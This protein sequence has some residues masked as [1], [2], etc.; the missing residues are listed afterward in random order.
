MK[1]TL[2]FTLFSIFIR[3]NAHTQQ[4]LHHE[5]FNYNA[6]I[7]SVFL[8]P[9]TNTTEPSRLLA[10]PIIQLNGNIPLVL[11]FD[12]L[13]A[14]YEQYHVKIIH[15]NYDWAP[16]VLSEIE[17]LAEYNDAIINNYAVSQGTK[18]SYY[19]YAFEVPP[20]KLSG[21]YLLVVYKGNR[22]KTELVLSKRFMVLEQ[23]VSLMADARPAQDPAKWKNFQQIDFELNYGNYNM[24]RSP[25]DEFKV[26]IRQNQRWDKTIENLTP[27]SIIES[28]Q[29]LLYRFFNNENLMPAG[30]EF[31]FFDIRTAYSKGIGVAKVQQGKEDEAWLTAQRNRSEFSHVGVRDL[32]GQYMIDNLDGGDGSIRSD[33]M[34]VTV[35]LQTTELSDNQQVYMNGAF[36]NWQLNDANKMTYDNEFGG[37]TATIQLKQ[38]LYDY[39]FVI[40]NALTQQIDESYFEGNFSDTGN[41]YEVFVYHKP[42]TARAERLVGYQ[43]IDT[44]RNR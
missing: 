30:N 20:V 9:Y 2:L 17:Y 12:D 32:N 24:V 21:N 39:D 18:V 27:S 26:L 6:N 40:K 7:K 37:Y 13:A 10:T 35:G 42:P 34:W 29:Q 8:Y 36:N 22:S 19:H 41:T 1:K 31:R 38:G 28:R 11:E 16:S 15:C 23:Q 3:F 44:N 43:I 33:Y 25:R 4:N 5:D 14:N